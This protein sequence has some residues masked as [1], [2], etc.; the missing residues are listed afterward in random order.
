MLIC[1]VTI[2]NHLIWFTLLYNNLSFFLTMLDFKRFIF[3]TFSTKKKARHVLGKKFFFS[4]PKATSK[5]REM[6]NAWFS[7][8]NEHV[9]ASKMV[10]FSLC[11]WKVY[12]SKFGWSLILPEP[13]IDPKNH[14][15]LW[16]QL[17]ASCCHSLL[18]EIVGYYEMFVIKVSR[19]IPQILP[20]TK[21]FFY[22]PSNLKF[23]TSTHYLKITSQSYNKL[24]S[25]SVLSN[26]ISQKLFIQMISS[27]A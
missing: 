21:D 15:L 20:Q 11:V 23:L 16:L 1:K 7:L 19:Y 13:Q 6:G 9:K 26:P 27:L 17:I 12:V 3:K 24:P 5:K 22:L 18:V 25:L 4:F 8:I 2:R 10:F 14:L